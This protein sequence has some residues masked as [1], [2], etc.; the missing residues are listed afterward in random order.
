M[1]TTNHTTHTFY[2]YRVS[3]SRTD[4]GGTETTISHGVDVL[5]RFCSKRSRI[6]AQHRLAVAWAESWEARA[7]SSVLFDSESFA[8]FVAKPVRFNCFGDIG[9]R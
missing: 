8:G 7:P 2:G 1:K 5:F 9:G 3:T 6:H 4:D